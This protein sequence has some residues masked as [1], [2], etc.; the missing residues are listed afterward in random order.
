MTKNAIARFGFAVAALA[1]C[2]LPMTTSV[3]HAQDTANSQLSVTQA[4]NAVDITVFGD[5][6]A[7]VEETRQVKLNAGR[8]QIQLNGVAGKYRADSLR[9]IDVKGNGTFTYKSATYQP[10]NLTAERILELSVGQTVTATVGSGATA[11]QVTGTLTSV[12][13]GQAIITAGDGTTYLTGTGDIAVPKLPAG[14]SATASLTIEANVS[15]AGTYDLHFLYETEGL[16]WSAKHSAIYN[17]D[18]RKLESFE[19]TVNVVNQSGT[20]FENANLWL[21]SGAVRG[22]GRVQVASYARSADA[23]EMAAPG[24]APVESVGERKVY[25]ITDRVTLGDGQSRQIPLFTGK[26]VPVEHEY[27]LPANSYVYDSGTGAQPVNVRLRV[28]NCDEHGL[29]TPLPA[30]LVKIYQRNSEKKLQL[31]ASTNVKELARDEVFELN[32]GTSSD[33]KAE[34]NLTKASQ[35]QP[36]PRT[37]PNQPV[38]QDQEY[39][40]T[41]HNFKTG[42][43]VDVVVE[44]AVPAEQQSVQPLTRKN[45]NQANGTVHAEPGKKGTLTYTLKVRTN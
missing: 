12:R 32:I 22:G 25:R 24:G 33:V 9:I 44:V 14:L 36:A 40:V 2:V 21:L 7:Q 31:T 35:P 1:L 10:A 28:K 5:G 26:D 3:A 11:R 38:Y 27:F 37:N 45:A 29:G 34:R 16:S 23:M 41:V 13:G 17:D 20:S 4:A 39:E 8:N 43:A 30:G 19:T 15:A 6:F 18:N 42:K